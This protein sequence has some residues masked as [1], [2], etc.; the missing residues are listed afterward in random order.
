MDKLG[1]EQAR[2]LVEVAGKQEPRLS[3]LILS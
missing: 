1:R 2:I 3:S